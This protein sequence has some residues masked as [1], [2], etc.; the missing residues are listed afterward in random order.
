MLLLLQHTIYINDHN[1]KLLQY[2]VDKI[3]YFDHYSIDTFIQINCHFY[4]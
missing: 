2:Q 4:L 3:E 1:I